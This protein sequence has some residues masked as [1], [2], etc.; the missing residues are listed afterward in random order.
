MVARALQNRGLIPSSPLN[1]SM[2]VIPNM[3]VGG[4]GTP[5]TTPFSTFTTPRS[6][7]ALNV[8]GMSMG[9]NNPGGRF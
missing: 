9:A 5:R 2:N 8:G 3:N 6:Y 4:M 1:V 7:S